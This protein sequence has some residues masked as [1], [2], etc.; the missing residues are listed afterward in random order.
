[1][2]SIQSFFIGNCLETD[3]GKIKLH[4]CSNFSDGCP[5]KPFFD[6]D[7]YKC[8]Y[9]SCVF[10]K[11]MHLSENPMNPVIPHSTELIPQLAL[12]YRNEP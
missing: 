7:F 11:P 3:E 1:M 12:I 10:F 5:D 8:E 9:F 4:S 2:I 6:Y